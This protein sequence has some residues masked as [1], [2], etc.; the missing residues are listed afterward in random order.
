ME[1]FRPSLFL[2]TVRTILCSKELMGIEP[3]AVRTTTKPHVV[4]TLRSWLRAV[5]SC[6]RLNRSDGEFR[7]FSS[8]PVYEM[9]KDCTI[10]SLLFFGF[11][12]KMY[13]LRQYWFYISHCF[14][15]DSF[16]AFTLTLSHEFV[17]FK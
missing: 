3:S 11:C 15:I 1:Q 8:A 12:I 10:I 13:S 2:R 9:S 17:N 6:Y 14:S 7:C 4:T 16:P 5:R